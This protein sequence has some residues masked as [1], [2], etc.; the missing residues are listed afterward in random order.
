MKYFHPRKC[1]KKTRLLYQIKKFHALK[2]LFG[3]ETANQ[4]LKIC[5]KESIIVILK[6]NGAKISKNCDI[7]SGLTFHNCKDY[8]NLYI[9]KNCHI[10]KNCFFD[11]R[12]KITIGNNVVIS[13]QNTI[14][15][16]IDMTNSS[17]SEYYP[18]TSKEV[19][20]NDNCYVGVNS[21]ILMGVELGT[22]SFISANSLVLKSVKPF[23]MVGG[24][25]S[26]FIRRIDETYK[27]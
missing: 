27:K 17:I 26:K 24:I 16:H 18:A 1:L 6:K 10:G 20:I 5:D 25:P 21:T 23:T 12:D 9:G 4:Y 7:E 8:S 3:F 19:I 22:S 14:I 13:M 15:T 11:L 2:Y